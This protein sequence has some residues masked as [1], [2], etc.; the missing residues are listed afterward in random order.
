MKQLSII[1]SCL[2]FAMSIFSQTSN[3]ATGSGAL[4]NTTGSGNTA[5]GADALKENTTGSNNSVHGITA[6]SSNLT[7]EYNTAIGSFSL[8]KTNKTN[9]S[10]NT[11]DGSNTSNCCYSLPSFS[12]GVGYSSLWNNSSQ[13]NTTAIGYKATGNNY[14]STAIGT[15]AQFSNNNDV[16]IGNG[17]VTSIGGYV[18][19]SNLSDGRTKK[20]VQHNVPGLTFI[21][22]LQ[23]VTYNFD[24]DAAV[25]LLRGGM[26]VDIPAFSHEEKS[27]REAKE[28][29][30]YSGFIAQ[31][32][33]KVAKSIGYDFSGVDVDEIGV[34]ALQYSEFVVPLVKA[35]QEFSK[36]N[37]ALQD[38]VDKLTVLVSQLLERKGKRSLAVAQP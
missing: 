4:S 26:D 33:E 35:A 11:V 30:L 34:Y 2:L 27:A 15:F 31:D 17:T 28:K 3:T 20:N 32:V 10:H 8:H 9:S 21:N 18:A 24:L 36:K 6:L 1:F 16:R 13:D 25:N 37:N 5:T 38:Q 29:Q 14:N 22:Q 19:W 12:V 23:P 7:G